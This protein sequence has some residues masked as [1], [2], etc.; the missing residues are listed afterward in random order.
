MADL[1]YISQ[2]ESIVNYKF[3][4]R[5]LIYKALTAPGAEGSKE[6]NE[7]ERQ[8]YDGNRKLSK[9]GENLI[10]SVLKMKEALGEEDGQDEIEAL[11]FGMIK[12]N[13][14]EKA[15]EFG[16][17]KMM[18]LNPR[19][20]G[21]ASPNTLHLAICAIVGAVWE[22]CGRQ[23]SVINSVVEFLLIRRRTGCKID[24]FEEFISMEM[25]VEDDIMPNSA[26]NIGTTVSMQTGL[27]ISNTRASNDNRTLS[28]ELSQSSMSGLSDIDLFDKEASVNEGYSSSAIE[29]DDSSQILFSISRSPSSQPSTTTPGRSMTTPC[30]DTRIH[31]QS[32]PSPFT[33][34]H[35]RIDEAVMS[36]IGESL[37]PSLRESSN[38]PHTMNIANL[39]KPHSTRNV[40]YVQK[41]R[42]LPTST[43]RESAKS[44]ALHSYI[45]SEKQRCQ[46]SGL[47]FSETEFDL[48]FIKIQN[49]S[50]DAHELVTLKT[51]YFAIG[52]PESLVALQEVFK[53]QRRTIAGKMPR[54]GYNL[55]FVERVKAIE[56]ITPN[57]AYHVLRKRCH[58]YQLFV[59]SS[60][61]SRKTSDGFVND[62]VQS[63][64]VQPRYQFGNPNNLEHSRVSESILRELY[65]TLEPSSEGYKEKKRFVGN[66]RRLGGRFD[67]M[68]RKFGYGIL[69]LLQLP[70]EELAGEPILV[71]TDEL[72]LSISDSKFNSFLLCLDDLQ[73]KY[74]RGI[75]NAISQAVTALFHDT[76]DPSKIYALEQV[77]PSQI[78]KN[79]KISYE[80]VNLI[81]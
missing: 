54:E 38:A 78:L 3:A 48:A 79:R 33:Q 24:P 76:L 1:D 47:P 10:Q 64:T 50:L 19:Q 66:L 8:Q 81:S 5:L 20:R 25:L 71:I 44:S 39:E 43:T 65:P 11:K 41:K 56:C 18:K 49:M 57:I 58:I 77:E 51:L 67:L 32:S 7:E 6:G 13:H 4:N 40:T 73:G 15:K 14:A 55:S 17:D 69:A 21:V 72:I 62:T 70:I 75:N 74:L 53:V 60:T 31:E 35:E 23:I 52:S 28:T 30:Q 12:R 46:A 68:V 80:L 59:D 34:F 16:I 36:G 63:I 22:D 27:G 2:L 45:N 26:M 61:G 42:K 29:I 9:V 37:E